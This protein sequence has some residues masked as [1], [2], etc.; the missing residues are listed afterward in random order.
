MTWEKI[1]SN[2]TKGFVK[3]FSIKEKCTE[4]EKKIYGVNFKTSKRVKRE[5]FEL[6]LEDAIKNVFLIKADYNMVDKVIK[7]DVLFKSLTKAKKFVEQKVKEFEL[8]GKCS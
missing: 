5:I 3:S 7:E 6:K 8:E 1:E 4:E 2:Y